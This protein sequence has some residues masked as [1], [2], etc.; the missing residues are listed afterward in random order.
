[1]EKD[2]RFAY[3]CPH[4]G[5]CDSKKHRE[6]V[7]VYCKLWPDEPPE[8]P[9]AIQHVAERRCTNQKCTGNN[10]LYYIETYYYKTQRNPN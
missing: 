9:D 3:R 10:K 8:R 6:Q 2:L 5:W 7:G 4:C 1:M